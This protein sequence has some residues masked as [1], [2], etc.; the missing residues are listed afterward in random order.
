MKMKSVRMSVVAGASLA[1]G[2]LSACNPPVVEENPRVCDQAD[3][4]AANQDAAFVK[5]EEISH[6]L[7]AI[8][9]TNSNLVW[10]EDKTKVLMVQWTSFKGYPIGDTVMSRDVFVT[11]A[12]QVK[13]FC[14]GI[15]AESQHARVVQYLGLAPESVEATN[16]R[17]FV[18]MWVEPASLFRPCADP[19][20]TDDTCGTTFP[21][22]TPQAH[23]DWV[24]RQ[25]SSSYAPWLATKYPWTAIGYTYD[26][27]APDKTK[28]QGA[29]EFIV[30]SGSTVTI[31]GYTG[32]DDYCAP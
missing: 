16:A 3:Y 7:V 15:A 19:E 20:I 24:N 22:G 4:D 18:E 1:F 8:V 2:L 9:P 30:R 10:N 12:P 14:Q 31:K 27:C 11:S 6:S 28:P 29:S 23:K 21:D 5:P 32:T 25:Y 26:W 17:Q 13:E